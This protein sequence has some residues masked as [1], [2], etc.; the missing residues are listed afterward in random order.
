MA[1]YALRINRVLDYMET[2]IDQ[3]LTLEELAREACFSVYHFHRIFTG[4][5]GERPFQLLQRLRLEKAANLLSSRKDLKITD[6][7]LQCGFANTPAFS[8]AF[9]SQF[10]RTPSQWKSSTPQNSN[11]STAESNQKQVYSDWIP[12]IEHIRGAQLWRMRKGSEERRV[13]VKTMG[14]M[15]LAYIRY[16][17]PYKGDGGLFHRLWNDLCTRAGASDLIGPESQYLA[18]YHDNPELTEEDKLR[19]TMAVSTAADFS[20][21]G[22]L[23]RMELEGGKY[24]FAHFRL[25]SSEYQQAWDWVY[26]HWLPVSGYLPGDSPAFELFPQDGEK[27]GDG[28]YPVVIAIPLVAAP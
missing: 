6:I 21:S 20:P 9:K 27:S 13:E 2:H 5:T 16:T 19:V 24:A 4:C 3:P 23:G 8:R 22:G 1:D 18:I 25:N 17:G 10:G 7:A 12:Y 26:R 11:L 28:R 14:S 15:V